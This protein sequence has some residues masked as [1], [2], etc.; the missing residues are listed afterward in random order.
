MTIHIRL[1]KTNVVNVKPLDTYL[2]LGRDI[3][4]S[5]TET[6]VKV[7]KNKR[8][9]SVRRRQELKKVPF[10]CS[11]VVNKPLH[12]DENCQCLMLHQENSADNTTLLGKEHCC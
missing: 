1:F 10:I 11:T 5:V 4:Q 12:N 7:D 8:R 2:E 9:E 3:I 6:K